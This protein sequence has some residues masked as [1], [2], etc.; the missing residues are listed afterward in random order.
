MFELGLRNIGLQTSSF[1]S[2]FANK[3]V[4]QAQDTMIT[5]YK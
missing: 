1:L 2:K 5:Y 3:M 4:A